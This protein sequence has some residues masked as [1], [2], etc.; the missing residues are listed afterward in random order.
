[1]NVSWE[2]VLD[3]HAQAMLAALRAVHDMLGRWPTAAEWDRGGRRPSSK[4]FVPHF[5][6]W[7]EARCAASSRE[8]VLATWLAT[9]PTPAFAICHGVVTSTAISA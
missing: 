3:D 8:T 4:T 2:P 1:V 5:G 6:S 9:A 7:R